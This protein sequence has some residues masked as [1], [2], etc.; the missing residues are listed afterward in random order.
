MTQ[1]ALALSNPL[2]IRSVLNAVTKQRGPHY[3]KD[4]SFYRNMTEAVTIKG[5]HY[6]PIKFDFAGK[7]FPT[8]G[9]GSLRLTG[10]VFG[11]GSASTVFEAELTNASGKKHQVAVK[12]RDHALLSKKDANHLANEEI[13]KVKT[14][15]RLGAGRVQYHGSVEINGMKGIILNRA[16][17]VPYMAVNPR[18][19]K[20]HTFREI[21]ALFD[22]L[23]ANKIAPGD[24]QMHID[25]KGR[26][27][28][29]DL[30]GINSGSDQGNK[31]LSVINEL[32]KRRT[33]AGLKAIVPPRGGPGSTGPGITMKGFFVDSA[34][35]MGLGYAGYGT[36]KVLERV[37]GRK[38]STTEQAGVYTGFFAPVIAYAGGKGFLAARSAGNGILGS[39]VSSGKGI[40][41]GLAGGIVAGIGA[42]FLLNDLGI[43]G[44]AHTIGTIGIGSVAAAHPAGI[45]LFAGYSFGKFLDWG[46]EKVFGQSLSGGL[47]DKIDDTVEGIKTVYQTLNPYERRRIRFEKERELWKE[48]KFQEAV[49]QERK[50]RA[51]ENAAIATQ[52]RVD[53]VKGE[54][55]KK[56]AKQA[57]AILKNA[58]KTLKEFPSLEA[59]HKM[60]AGGGVKNYQLE[61]LDLNSQ[62]RAT[63]LIKI[64]TSGH[65]WGSE[66]VNL[67]WIEGR[68]PAMEILKQGSSNYY[69]YGS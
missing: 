39:V 66:K 14:M 18:W 52:K 5:V 45:A 50:F 43:K 67:T 4:P 15:E 10:K 16:P 62:G 17:G 25:A 9:G 49:A 44:D 46:S 29:V 28:L 59:I 48:R 35:N 63:Y 42:A 21:H 68:E 37:L 33:Q 69:L 26:V 54:G 41:K 19:I 58:N 60:L 7:S 30:E 38:L 53:Q 13:K 31:R 64:R 27:Y 22:I 6:F 40:G 8:E 3:F 51:Q 23:D 65:G 32:N 47:A 20:P 34:F 2:I 12:L 56:E 36:V 55:L 11:Q 24:F 57:L 61:M 1:A